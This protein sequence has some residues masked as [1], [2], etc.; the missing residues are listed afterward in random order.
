MDMLKVFDQ[1][2]LT[3][4]QYVVDGSDWNVVLK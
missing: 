4:F 3:E 2:D 1:D